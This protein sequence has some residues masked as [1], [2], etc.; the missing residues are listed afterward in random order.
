MQM[1]TEPILFTQRC[2]GNHKI[3]WG[4]FAQ[5]DRP[6]TAYEPVNTIQP[7]QINH[8]DKRKAISLRESIE[9]YEQIGQTILDP[10]TAQDQDIKVDETLYP[11]TSGR[12]F[13]DIK[14]PVPTCAYNGRDIGSIRHGRCIARTDQDGHM[15]G[16]HRRRPMRVR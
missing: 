10:A 1:M 13:Y 15:P 12:N 16:R 9:L 11:R 7:R 8:D 3:L 2:N 14:Q 5:D 4:R 6:S